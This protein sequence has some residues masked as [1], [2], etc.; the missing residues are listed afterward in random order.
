VIL[1]VFPA[2]DGPVNFARDEAMMARARATGETVVRIYAWDRPVVSFGRNE[3]VV[4]RFSAERIEA[5][6]LQAVRRPTGG[7]ALL[8]RRELTYA[9]AGRARDEQTLR[10]T[11]A[12]IHQLLAAALRLLGVDTALADTAAAAAP[13][14]ATC[15][16]LP[17]R[18]ELVVDT[19]KL[20]AS[21]QWREAGAYL[22]HG[23]VLIDNDHP[24]LDA[25]T[26][27][28][29]RLPPV[30]PPATLR[31]LLGRSPGTQELAAALAAALVADGAEPRRIDSHAL[32][33]ERVLEARQRHYRD[34][35][36]TWR[37]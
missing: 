12:A 17:T 24:L 6:G 13:D 5:N 11:Y 25:I 36:W 15:F 37:R 2:A 8:H 31:E 22:Q 26:E 10:G 28:D 3:R 32:L 19:R 18:G 30:P 35:T 27:R 23:S 9:V 33:D 14:G 7:R 29:V 16:A 21:A 20:V 34:A 4:G 1:A